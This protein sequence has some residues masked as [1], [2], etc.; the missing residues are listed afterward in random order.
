M[1]RVLVLIAALAVAPPLAAQ[2]GLDTLVP[3]MELYGPGGSAPAFDV[4]GIRCAALYG[5]Q[6][7]HGREYRAARP[8]A[9]QM[10]AYQSNLDAARQVRVEGGLGHASAR[11][12]VERDLFRVMDLYVAV[13]EDNA[14]RGRPWND[15]ALL[16]GDIAYCYLLDR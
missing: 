9:R 15:G 10:E 3:L 8:T 16:R 13:M 1:R 12:A 11:E 14:R 5:A 4:A 6:N 2:E 7:R